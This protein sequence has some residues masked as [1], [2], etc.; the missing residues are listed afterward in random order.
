MA[1][2]IPTGNLE[3]ILHKIKTRSL[4]G[5]AFTMGCQLGAQ[6]SIDSGRV[7]NTSGDQAKLAPG[8]VW[9]IYGKNLGPAS[10]AQVTGTNYAP[11]LAGTSV[12]F[13]PVAGGAV[14]NAS[15][16]YTLATQVGGLIPSSIAPGT[17][18]V[19]VTYNQQTSA[20]QNV[21]VVAR[22]MGIAT[23]NGLGTGPAQ[24]TINNV[25]GGISLVRYTS[26]AVDAGGY[27]YILTPAHPGDTVSLWGTG[28]GADSANDTG[29]TSGDQT[30]AGNF[31]VMLG[32]RVITPLYSGAVA[33]YPG[34]WVIVFTLPSDIDLDCFAMLQVSAGGEL[35]NVTS[36]AIAA[37]GQTVCSSAGYSPA[38]LAKLD[39]G[40]NIVFAGMTV[41]KFALDTGAVEIVGGPFNLYSAAKWILPYSGPKF[42]PCT[43]LDITY[44]GDFPV[45]PDAL[46]DAGT[47]L[48]L[49]GPGATAGT[50]VP[51]IPGVVGPVYS[52][53][54]PAGTL[55]NGGTYRLTGTGG[56]QVGP[57]TATAT[58][59]N[60]F[61]L[62]NLSTV[63][64][65]SKPFTLNWTGSGFDTVVVQLNGTILGSST[66]QVVVTCAVPGSSGT[67]SI[68]AAALAYMPAVTA[69]SS[70]AVGQIS[71][72]AAP[73]V[74]GMTSAQSSTATTLTPNLVGGGQVDFGAFTA[75]LGV[76]KSVTIQ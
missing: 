60:S 18:A 67:L 43:V 35:S 42:G 13:T 39:A 47:K 56:T 9:V 51:A 24:A 73:G 76:V 14:V 32:S 54:L 31:K 41:G 61:N 63:V 23:A 72:A 46:L 40:G 36:L 28:G 59:P 5:M 8:V 30:A 68:P 75:F 16:W 22:S 27:H 48:T 66:H 7:L 3:E 74:A 44:A 50:I 4:I 1:P 25:N 2:A 65:R 17:Y 10:L 62:T 15:I 21:T 70:S 34:L 69:G 38:T 26:N 55:V 33:G 12:T 20:P 58:L 37:A 52:T 64:D 6:P 29:G 49:T 53:T 19:R 71:I 11:S 45:A 57:F